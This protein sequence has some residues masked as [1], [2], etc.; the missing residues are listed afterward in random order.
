MEG[1]EPT[2]L[3]M[4][5]LAVWPSC[6]SQVDLVKG[7]I[8]SPYVLRLF[9]TMLSDGYLLTAPCTLVVLNLQHG[10]HTRE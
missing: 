6:P 1:V 3:Y 9:V 7:A 5:R 2:S 10:L 8:F 4:Y